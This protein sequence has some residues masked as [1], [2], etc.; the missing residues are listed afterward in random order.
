MVS[1][2]PP[3]QFL[4]NKLLPARMF[5]AGR[6][7]SLGVFVLLVTT[8]F[9]P[10]SIRGQDFDHEPINYAQSKANNAVSR[11]QTRLEDGTTKLA[12]D[13]QQGYLA[14][15]LAELNVPISS[16]TLVF[17]KTSLQRNRIAPRT[18]RALYF[19]D[20][21]YVGY[22]QMG[23]VLELSAADPELGT[24]FYTLYQ[25]TKQP[26]LVR[27]VDN[28]LQCH[29]SAMTRGVPGH[30]LRSVYVDT[31]GFPMLAMGTHR[32]DQTTP[33][34]NRW[35][36]WYVTGT[37][38]EQAHLGNLVLSNTPEREPVDNAAG[39]N[40]TELSKR[41]R[42]A[43]YLSPHSDL[44]ALMV[45]EHQTEMHNLLTRANFQTREA[46]FAEVGLNKSL[47]EPLDHRWQ[48]TTTRIE[49]ACEALVKY[50]F[51]CGEPP[52]TARLQGTS[53]FAEDFARQGPRDAKGRSL[54]DFDLEHRMFKYP[55][56]YLIYSESF[57]ALPKEA[58]Q[59]V[60]RRMRAVLTGADKS[61]EFAHL[62]DADRT[63]IL[64]IIQGTKPGLLDD[65][66]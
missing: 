37:H 31:A 62:S 33:I 53:T 27:Q 15:L 38:G 58:L 13:D 43:E 65:P 39:Q 60:V 36:G 44:I 23:D 54:R 18:P 4:R 7:Q 42:T 17:S 52:L 56:S 1:T 12:R 41:L 61:K 55:C 46:M 8:G 28:C 51:Y 45:L 20:D 2:L 63:A 19:N 57:D 5:L 10:A 30:L 25:E 32:V 21:V 35:G 47:G 3:I 24:V 49:S 22:C 11:L 64:E 26:R 48:S 50:L 34:S 66:K 6:L 9:P 29:G 16:Q 40:V 14:A 59:V